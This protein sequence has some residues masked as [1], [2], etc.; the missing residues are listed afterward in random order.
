MELHRVI[1]IQSYQ[2]VTTPPSGRLHVQVEI[3]LRANDRLASSDLNGGVTQQLVC[4][5][6]S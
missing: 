1:S 6:L 5:Q 4:A 3:E 2:R